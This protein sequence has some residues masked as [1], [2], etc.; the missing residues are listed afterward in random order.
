MSRAE[1]AVANPAPGVAAPIFAALGDPTRLSLLLRLSDGESRSI[2]SLSADGR[3]TRQALTKH[4]KVLEC[5][6]LVRSERAGRETRFAFR[7]EPVAAARSY[8]DAVGAQW[9]ASLGR[10]KQFVEADDRRS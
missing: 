2:S 4:L 5:A 6:G 8:L 3:I 9:E 1:P 7:P 10:L